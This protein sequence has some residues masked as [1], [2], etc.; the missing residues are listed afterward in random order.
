MLR[1]KRIAKPTANAPITTH[2]PTM[3]MYTPTGKMI[4]TI[5]WLIVCAM[6]VTPIIVQRMSNGAARRYP[7]GFRFRR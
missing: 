3:P 7:I 1:K 4:P 6:T 5:A 2:D